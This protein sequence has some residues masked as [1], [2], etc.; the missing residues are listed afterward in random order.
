MNKMIC[1]KRCKLPSTKYMIGVNDSV[2]VDIVDN[3]V[4][5]IGIL[6]SE[7]EE[8]KKWS[9]PMYAIPT[10]IVKEHFMTLADWRDKQIDKILENESD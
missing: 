6:K 2:V 7:T 1:I 9:I 8:E 5:Y 4:S 10:N 3:Y